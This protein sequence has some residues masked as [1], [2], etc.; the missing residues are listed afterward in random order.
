[1]ADAALAHV[2]GVGQRSGSLPAFASFAGDSAEM[3]VKAECINGQ[4][5]VVDQVRG[6][7]EMI[8]RCLVADFIDNFRLLLS[9]LYQRLSPLF[10]PLAGVFGE[11][12]FCVLRGG[13]LV[14]YLHPS[15]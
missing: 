14:E 15:V 12:V 5:Q 10:C 6:L 3:A 7:K 9:K 13:K 11:P 2:A 1:M 8:V 4:M